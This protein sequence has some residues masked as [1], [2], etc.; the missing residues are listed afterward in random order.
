MQFG[1]AWGWVRVGIWILSAPPPPPPPPPLGI[2][3]QNAPKCTSNQ[4]FLGE[5][6]PQ[7]PLHVG[8]VCPPPPP[9]IP[10]T[11]LYPPPP[12]LT[13]ICVGVRELKISTTHNTPIHMSSYTPTVHT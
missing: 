3:A 4:N 11:L 2:R 9:Y 7:A 8:H 1:A 10:K 6:I 5:H 13:R 12:S